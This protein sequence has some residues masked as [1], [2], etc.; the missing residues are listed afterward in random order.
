MSLG[1]T[2]T[3]WKT[4]IPKNPFYDLPQSM[5]LFDQKYEIFTL[6]QLLFGKVFD[7]SA[8]TQ[9]D[10]KQVSQFDGTNTTI[11]TFSTSWNFQ[12]RSLLKN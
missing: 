1:K 6:F 4:S 2:I 5:C 9:N 3:I 7:G 12:N 11:S 8:R 10:Q